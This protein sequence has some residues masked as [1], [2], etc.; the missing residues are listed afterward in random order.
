MVLTE[1]GGDYPQFAGALMGVP[2]PRKSMRGVRLKVFSLSI[3]SMV[4][5]FYF[6]HSDICITNS[7]LKGCNLSGSNYLRSIGAYICTYGIQKKRVSPHPIL[8]YAVVNSSMNVSQHN[9][10]E[11]HGKIMKPWS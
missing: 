1:P 11:T 10:M 5:Y 9:Q 6:N 7:I 8:L 3:S 2:Q 4:E